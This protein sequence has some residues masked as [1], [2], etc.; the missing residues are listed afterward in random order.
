MARD[1]HMDSTVPCINALQKCRSCCVPD[2]NDAWYCRIYR[3]TPEG[4]SDLHLHEDLRDRH[5]VALPA[6]APDLHDGVRVRD[7]RKDLSQSA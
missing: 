6:N 7:E 1:A 5:V 3:S 4:P 2:I